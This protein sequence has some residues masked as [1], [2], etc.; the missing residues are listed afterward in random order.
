MKSAKATAAGSACLSGLV[1]KNGAGQDEP[2]RPVFSA[3]M[4][5]RQVHDVSPA[6]SIRVS[7]SGRLGGLLARARMPC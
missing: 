4:R 6:I 7:S 2:R 1:I 5:D 3:D